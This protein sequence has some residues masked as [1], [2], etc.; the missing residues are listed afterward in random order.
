MSY[1]FYYE[2]EYRKKK[3]GKIIARESRVGAT[4]LKRLLKQS[5][6]FNNTRNDVDLNLKSF[7]TISRLPGFD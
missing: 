6:V 2:N 5:R 4:A 1:I 3:S 7:R